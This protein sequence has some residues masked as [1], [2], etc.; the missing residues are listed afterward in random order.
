MS[1]VTMIGL[2][3]L[4]IVVMLVVMGGVARLTLALIRRPLERRIAAV[5]RPDEILRQDLTANNF[6]LESWG[7]WQGEAMGRSC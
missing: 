1:T 4:S 2:I 6:G 3:V 7:V 5:Y